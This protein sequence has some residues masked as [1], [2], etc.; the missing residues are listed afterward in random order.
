MK[1]QDTY[2]EVKTIQFPGLVARV[3]IPELTPEERKARMKAIYKAAAN[4][5]KDQK[6]K[7]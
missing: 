5:L 3:Y 2:K 7:N 4:L 6:I 1:C